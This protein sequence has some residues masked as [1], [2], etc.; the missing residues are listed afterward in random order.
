MTSTTI[1]KIGPGIRVLRAERKWSQERV[2][3]AAELSKQTIIN[4]EMNR[5]NPDLT[6]LQR[7][8]AAFDLSLSEFLD[9]CA[10]EDLNPQP[11]G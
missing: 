10:R 1:F 3:R 8:A 11:A 9:L 7:L 2:A 5:S 4:V 6:T